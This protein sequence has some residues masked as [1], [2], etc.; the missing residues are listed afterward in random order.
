MIGT[1]ALRDPDWLQRI[2]HTF[3]DKIVLGL[4]AKNGRVATEGW[5]KVSDETALDVARRCAGW[6]LAALVYTDISRDGM[7]AGPN[8]AGL[9]EMV[10]AVPIPVIASG[11]I[12][13]VD[14]VRRLAALAVAGCIIGRALYEGKI[15]LKEL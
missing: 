5:L 7:L 6:P 15:D 2:C 8:L 13:S 4:D 14:D 3:P 11:G 9:G 10:A 1:R 12:T